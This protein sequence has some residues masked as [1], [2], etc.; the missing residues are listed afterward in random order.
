MRNY[1]LLQR[2]GLEICNLE[3]PVNFSTMMFS[4]RTCATSFKMQDD[5]HPLKDIIQDIMNTSSSLQKRC[6]IGALAQLN[7]MV[8]SWTT[9]GK[10]TTAGSLLVF[11]DNVGEDGIST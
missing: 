2:T 4:P 8:S 3:W 5:P 7:S 9:I 1:F 10:A 11:K 6:T